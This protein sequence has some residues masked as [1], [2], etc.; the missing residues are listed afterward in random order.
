MGAVFAVAKCEFIGLGRARVVKCTG[1]SKLAAV[2]KNM[3]KPDEKSNAATS[4]VADSAD[5]GDALRS[6]YEEAVSEDIPE[7]LLDLLGK[8]N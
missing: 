6:A 8:L 5:I 7:E 2:G 3:R 4:D 1:I